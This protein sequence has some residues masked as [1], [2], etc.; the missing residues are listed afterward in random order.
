MHGQAASSRIAVVSLTLGLAALA[1][2]ACDRTSD[3]VAGPQAVPAPI[4]ASVDPGLHEPLTLSSSNGVLD[5][6]LTAAPAMVD[7]GGQTVLTPVFNGSYI[8]PTLRVKRGDL[9]RITLVNGSGMMTNLHTHGFEVTPKGISDNIFRVADVGASLTYEYNIGANHPAGQF[10]YHPHVHG[11][12]SAQTKY[13]LSGLIIVEGMQEEIPALQGLAERVLILKDAQVAGTAIDT[14]LEIGINATRTV[15]GVVNPTITMAPGETQFWRISNQSANLYYRLVL[16]GHTLYQ[17]GRDGNHLNAMQANSEV[18]LTPGSRADVVV[19]MNPGEEGQ[20]FALRTLAVQTGV[21][22]DSYDEFVLATVSVQGAPVAP[23]ALSGITMT[24]LR[25]LRTLVTNTRGITFQ[26]DRGG[27]FFKV[28]GQNFDMNKVN[29]RVRL[30][31]VERW[32]IQNTT[33]EWHVFHIHQVQF[34]LV[35]VNGNP[36]PFDGYHDVVNVPEKGSVTVII[37]FAAATSAGKYV[38][39]CHIL[40]HEDRGMMAIIQVG[41][42]EMTM[43]MPSSM[44]GMNHGRGGHGHTP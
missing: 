23:L 5:V 31:N 17:V 33:N 26:Q 30:G 18:F 41:K 15:N 34:Q 12:A 2:Q 28:N 35:A 36:V 1:S 7:I 11:N 21:A 32:T 3:R 29:T 39:H 40:D 43:D 25:D 24:P 22:G 16:D 38:Y 9:L 14:G 10:W 8:P 27:V 20:R 19:Q 37:P 6:T 44:T 4:S 42:D 13:G